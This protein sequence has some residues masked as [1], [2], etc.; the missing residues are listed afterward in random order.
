[1]IEGREQR[2]LSPTFPAVFWPGLCRRQVVS[3]AL[4]REPEVN[5]LAVLHFVLF[6]FES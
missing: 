5:D 1:M 6:P 3:A 4:D 2:R